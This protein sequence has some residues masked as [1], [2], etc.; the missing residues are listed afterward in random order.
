MHSKEHIQNLKSI[1]ALLELEEASSAQNQKDGAQSGQ[2]PHQ[3]ELAAL[4]EKYKQANLYFNTLTFESVRGASWGILSAIDAIA[5]NAVK[6]VFCNVRPPS[7]HSMGSAQCESGGFCYTN[8]IAVAARYAQK[9]YQERFR[10][11]AIIDWDAHHGD[12][13]QT[14][15]YGDDTVL[16]ISFH[17]YDSG[18]KC[19]YTFQGEGQ[20]SGYNINIPWLKGIHP[21]VNADKGDQLVGDEEYIFL[22]RTIVF[23][24]LQS[25]KPDLVMVACGFDSAYGDNLGGIGLKRKGYAYMLAKT[26]QVCENIVVCLEGGY[27]LRNLVEYSEAVVRALLGE[28]LDSA[29][30]MI[31]QT[32]EQI[33]QNNHPS[34]QLVQ[35]QY[36]A[37]LK[38]LLPYW[39]CLE[40]QAAAHAE[41][42]KQLDPKAFDL[43]ELQTCNIF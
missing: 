43:P 38:L 36:L 34:E 17:R 27:I 33:E 3:K 25:F 11:V 41:K 5:N 7:H 13:L 37:L 22:F 10:R 15:F 24:V 4:L 42:I 12:G 8:N 19:H 35:T 2:S 32:L 28:G 16:Y 30:L 31:G 23:T 21:W 26:K 39:P 14:V 6:S 40:P 1:C 20:G 29:G 9:N 18:L